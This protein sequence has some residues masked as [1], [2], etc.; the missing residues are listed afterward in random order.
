LKAAR[1]LVIS[2]ASDACG[3]YA[4]GADAPEAELHL[5]K[6]NLDA[7]LDENEEEQL[8]F[9][10]NPKMLLDESNVNLPLDSG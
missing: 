1:I 3:A 7:D 10:E 5:D 4:G 8:D 2:D 6:L 9:N